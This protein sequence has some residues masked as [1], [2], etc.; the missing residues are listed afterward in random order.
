MMRLL[1]ESKC[2][3]S[4][5]AC[6]YLHPRLEGDSN[7]LARTVFMFLHHATRSILISDNDDLVYRAQVQVP[8]HMASRQAGNQQLL[9]VVAPRV[10]AKAGIAGPRNLRLASRADRVVPP[11]LAVA[12]R[13]SAVIAS[14]VHLHFILML[15]HGSSSR[16]RVHASETRRPFP[17]SST[18]KINR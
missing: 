8:K 16:S 6:E 17:S 5:R 9:R 4:A 12:F 11:I 15:L 14:P 10:T 1:V 2:L 18:T 3:L 13:A 7:K